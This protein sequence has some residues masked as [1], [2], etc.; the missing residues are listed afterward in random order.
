MTKAILKNEQLQAQFNKD[1]FIKI[2]LLDSKDIQALQETY[3][4][5]FPTE[6]TAFFSSSYLNNFEK[7]IEIS[8]RIQKIILPKLANYLIDFRSFGSSFLVKGQGPQSEM[9]MHQDWTIVDESKYSAIN[10]W[11]PLVNTN[12]HNGTLELL[13]GSHNWL[14]TI[15]APTLPFQFENFKNDI[16][17]K[18]TIMD[19]KVGDAVLINQATVH[20]SKP[21]LSKT[22]RVAITTGITSSEAPLRFY[23]W[24][25]TLPNKLELFKQND[26]FLLRFE[27]FHEAIF[28]R[29]VQGKSNGLIDYNPRAIS[30]DKMDELLNN[31]SETTMQKASLI[32]SWISNFYK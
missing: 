5:Y 3:S 16:Y 30:R 4:H 28:Q 11:T 26:D 24:N 23:Y 2:S 1:G 7:K 21:N 22:D 17:S 20:Y 29:P 32:K 6:T 18:L 13:R 27:Q 9:P 31:S 12:E 19:A 15:R 25:K 10:I 14:R 8:S